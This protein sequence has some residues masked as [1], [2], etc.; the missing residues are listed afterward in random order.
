[1]GTNSSKTIKLICIKTN[2]VKVLNRCEVIYS[3]YI[4]P[5]K[6]M[7]KIVGH[8]AVQAY[9]DKDG[10]EYRP[11]YGKLLVGST[12]HE[13]DYTKSNSGWGGTKSTHF[14]CED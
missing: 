13:I 4:G 12:F 9:F 6:E 2:E 5:L 8:S 3:P 7:G 14:R 1:M 11:Y 10:N